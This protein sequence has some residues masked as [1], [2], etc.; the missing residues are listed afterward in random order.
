MTKLPDLKLRHMGMFVWDIEKMSA[1]YQQVIGFVVTDKGTVRGGKIV[2]LSKH[3]RSHHQLA[4]E[5]RR[6]PG[7]GLGYGLQQISFQVS[8]LDDLRTMYR[9]IKARDDVTLLQ[10]V[11]HGL[12][13][14]LYFCDPEENRVEIYM[15]T[16]WHI[17]QPFIAELN[18]ELPDDEIYRMTEKLVRTEPTVRPIAEWQKEMETRVQRA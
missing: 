7:R 18:L 8:A 11:D 1:F 9:L 2:F 16:P 14:S 4:M 10:A 15:D 5:E 6:P 12:S 17:S 13:W 3:P